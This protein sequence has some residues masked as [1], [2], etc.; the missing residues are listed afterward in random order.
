[1]Q[2]ALSR[3]CHVLFGLL[4]VLPA[5]WVAASDSAPTVRIATG[6]LSGIHDAKAGQRSLGFI[7]HRYLLGGYRLRAITMRWM[8]DVP[9]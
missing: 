5:S 9:S 8:S 3:S 7:A 4:L 6:T 1:M 2:M